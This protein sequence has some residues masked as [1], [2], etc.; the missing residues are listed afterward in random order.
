MGAASAPKEE[1]EELRE[2]LIQK[3]TI[4][5][6]KLLE[7]IIS[8]GDY[9]K[10]DAQLQAELERAEKKLAQLQCVRRQ[11]ADP[12]CRL[13]NIRRMLQESGILLAHAAWMA[14]HIDRIT[15]FPSELELFCAAGGMRHL[16]EGTGVETEKA[17][18]GQERIFSVRIP[19]DCAASPRAVMEKQEAHILALMRG[20]PGITAQQMA[21][22]M[23]VNTALIYRR[24]K[25]LKTEGRVCYSS[26]N[27]RGNWIVTDGA[28]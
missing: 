12:A 17:K 22:D 18:A 3:K 23:G 14:Q 7:G 27:G 28:K 8:D 13:E 21:A 6:D 2:A 15:V 1:T 19:L 4:L 9:R 26:P 24:I 10:K 11:E 25:K 20:R 5:L 16:A